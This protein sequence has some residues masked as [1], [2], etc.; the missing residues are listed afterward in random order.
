[1]SLFLIFPSTFRR[2]P[3]GTPRPCSP[4]PPPPSPPPP[5]SIFDG[6]LPFLL[7]RLLRRNLKVIV[8]IMATASKEADMAIIMTVR[9]GALLGEAPELDCVGDA[10]ASGVVELWESA[11]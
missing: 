3:P 11:L 8:R 2:P 7:L 5:S 1:M 6:R 9:L 4:P 10:E